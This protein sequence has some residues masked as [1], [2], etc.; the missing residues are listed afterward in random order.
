M[1]GGD[2]QP[3]EL[4]FAQITGVLQG[5][6]R[7][8]SDA[9]RARAAQRKA[10]PVES[11]PPPAPPALPGATLAERLGRAERSARSGQIEEAIEIAQTCLQTLEASADLFQLGVCHHVLALS[12]QYAGRMHEAMLAGYRAIDLLD[13]AD[14]PGRLVSILALQS[15]I[16]ARLGEFRE[17]LELLDRATQIL[18]RL[19]DQPRDTCIFWSNAGA[20]YY[21]L[22]QLQ[23][24]VEAAEDSIKLLDRFDDPDLAAIC[25][26]N[27][28]VY[29]VELARGGGGIT[30]A[31]ARCIGDLQEHIGSLEVT[32]HHHLVVKCVETA[33]DTLIDLGWYDEA[34]ALLRRGVRSAQQIGSRPARG[35]LELRAAKVERLCHQYRAAGAHI[36]S[37]LE[38]LA[39]GHDK[40]ELARTHLE[41]CLLHEAQCH[42][43]A[44][45]E[46]HKRYAEMREALLKSQADNRAQ[47]MAVRLD[48]ER[49]R[50]ETALLRQRNSELE[51]SLGQLHDEAGRQKRQPQGDV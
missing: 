37:A 8:P 22:G 39:E 46:C 7:A 24:S 40:D 12:H 16:L 42:W 44:A 15:L 26:G 17:A 38:L 20:T 23:R 29:R 49:S 50:V 13:R 34:R 27:L 9:R 5:A 18:P 1:G 11:V 2:S 51:H 19:V 25:M 30:S 36:A 32:G 6:T 31:L 35:A 43:R 48:L 3:G 4:G 45:L 33:G 47:A 41:N 10:P 21:A 14:V 28:L